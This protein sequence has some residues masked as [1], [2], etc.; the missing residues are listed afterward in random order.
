M[1]QGSPYVEKFLN[2]NP[3]SVVK[4]EP[5]TEAEE[6]ELLTVHLDPLQAREQLT[7]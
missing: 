3:V 5:V 6:P 2:W 1:S 4:D 7:A